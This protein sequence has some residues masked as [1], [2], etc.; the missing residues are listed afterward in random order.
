M[1]NLDDCIGIV[2]SR[3]A[4]QI[5]EAFTKKLEVHGVTR[6]QWIAIYYIGVGKI[7]TQ[8][9][10]ADRINVKEPTIV[11]LIDRL[12]KNNLVIRCKDNNDRRVTLLSLT[13]KGLELHKCLLPVGEEFSKQ[14][15]ANISDDELRIFNKVMAQ[16]MKNTENNNF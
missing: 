6:T 5:S 3:G 11:T 7:V 8:K 1:F 13:E 10:L 4:K 16:M 9:E 15:T 14:I 12:Q 2:T